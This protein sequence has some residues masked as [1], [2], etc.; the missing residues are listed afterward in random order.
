MNINYYIC[1]CTHFKEQRED[2]WKVTL[3]NSPGGDETSL[4]SAVFLSHIPKCESVILTIKNT[5]EI[6]Y[7]S[8]Q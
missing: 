7:L 4:I 1:M 8:P 6:L 3:Q 2:N 5:I